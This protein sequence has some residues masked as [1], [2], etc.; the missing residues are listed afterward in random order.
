MASETHVVQTNDEDIVKNVFLL[1]SD[2]SRRLLRKKYVGLETLLKQ[3]NKK[4][5]KINNRR[6]ACESKCS[7]IYTNR[8][9]CT[10]EKAGTRNKRKHTSN[11]L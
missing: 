3:Q 8:Q 6:F 2:G 10:K 9:E 4:V 11:V 7:S 5:R 1:S